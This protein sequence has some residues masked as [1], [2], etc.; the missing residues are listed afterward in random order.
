MVQFEK[1]STEN[2]RARCLPLCRELS[3]RSA[4]SMS[5]HA[6]ASAGTF[7]VACLLWK[8]Y[9]LFV[10]HLDFT[11]SSHWPYP[12]WLTLPY[13]PRNQRLR[14]FE[15]G[16]SPVPRI[17]Q[18]GEARSLPALLQA[19]QYWTLRKDAHDCQGYIL[20][21]NQMPLKEEKSQTY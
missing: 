11:Q 13:T 8:H 21:L 2:N 16:R 5:Y 18:W 1:S 12:H 3:A 17:L 9:L 20:Q 10:A 15:H 19:H 6:L 14:E 4:D 7:F